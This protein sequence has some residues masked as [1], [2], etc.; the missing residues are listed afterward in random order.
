MCSECEK[1]WSDKVGQNLPG[2]QIHHSTES[3]GESSK[4][5]SGKV[6]FNVVRDPNLPLVFISYRENVFLFNSVIQILYC[7]SLF[8]DYIN[9][10]RSPLKGIVIKIRKLFKEIEIG[11]EPSRTS[12]YMTYLTLFRMGGRD[13]KIPRT[14]FSPVTSTNVGISPQNFLTFSLT[15]LPHCCKIS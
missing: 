9:K 6:D 4:R 8:R 11:K 2:W 12:N 1:I 14:N 7:I 3:P 15:L 10:L 13:Q 5:T